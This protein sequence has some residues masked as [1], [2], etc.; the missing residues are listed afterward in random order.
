VQI[1]TDAVEKD[2]AFESSRHLFGSLA[3]G[4]AVQSKAVRLE[5]P[6]E[7]PAFIGHVEFDVE[8]LCLQGVRDLQQ[9]L[10]VA[11][12]RYEAHDG[13]GR[14]F[15]LHRYFSHTDTLR[16]DGDAFPIAGVADSVVGRESKPPTAL[17]KTIHI[18][19]IYSTS[20]NGVL[21]LILSSSAFKNAY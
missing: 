17:R 1:E 16:S 19:Y 4:R 13:D 11:I 14:S 20:L 15:R 5:S 18:N 12:V 9:R 7:G 10:Q 8:P 21:K 3:M 2:R 6:N